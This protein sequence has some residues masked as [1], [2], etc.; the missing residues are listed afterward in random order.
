MSLEWVAPLRATLLA[1]LVLAG[2]SPPRVPFTAEEQVAAHIAGMP[3][4]RLWADAGADALDPRAQEIGR[5]EAL[6]ASRSF[7]V[8]AL[9]GGGADGAF[10]AGLLVG[11][12][13]AGDRPKFTVVTGVSVGA[14]IAPFAFLG[15]DRDPDLR[16]VFAEGAAEG[17]AQLRGPEGLFGSGLFRPEPLSEL[18]ARFA[19]ERMLADVAVEHARG[20]RLLILTT[21]LDAQRAV[22]WDLG[23]IASSGHPRAL[24]LFRSVL[25]A[26]ASVPGVFPPIL[27]EVEAFGSA[28]SEMHVDG[29]VTGNVL[30]V[31]EALL[32]SHR[33]FFP[34]STPGRL[35]VVM[36]NSIEPDFGVV[37][38]Q[39]LQVAA[40]AV[41]TAVK[42]NTANVLRAA[43][44]FARQ[45]RFEFNLA[46]I[47]SEYLGG[48]ALQFDHD[49]MRRLF[50]YG[51]E[52]G[53]GDERWEQ[54]LPFS[55]ASEA[56]PLGDR[57]ATNL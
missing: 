16:A 17:L 2:C 9:S 35:F 52:K 30:L 29:G 33:R 44:G 43:Y 27:V 45:L 8:L 49:H 54:D 34:R 4:V 7:D 3:G 24:G 57:V 12:S 25:A 1:V 47:T 39:T 23:A 21:N 20:R 10:G 19:D 31:P 5:S 18:I 22:I 6:R 15:P 36:N 46:H 50:E 11:W 42:T 56:R 53:R 32:R 28:F 37:D 48:N 41:S 14:L 38:N 55:S 40:R 26:S 51:R 13:E